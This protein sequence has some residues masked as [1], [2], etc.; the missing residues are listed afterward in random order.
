MI[1]K[2]D[3]EPGAK[4]LQDAVSAPQLGAE[5]SPLGPLAG[6]HSGN[7]RAEV[8]V[9]EVRTLSESKQGR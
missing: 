4:E 5:V 1:L 6:N 2:C 7:G 9:W 3:N 8:A